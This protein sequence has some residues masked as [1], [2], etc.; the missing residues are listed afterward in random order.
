MGTEQKVVISKYQ[1][2]QNSN[3][4]KFKTVKLNDLMTVKTYDNF[5]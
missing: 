1:I 4:Y 3:Y 5:S 2:I